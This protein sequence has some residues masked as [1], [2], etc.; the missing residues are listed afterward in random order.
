MQFRWMSASVLAMLLSGCGGTDTQTD[1]VAVQEEKTVMETSPVEG[2][3]F[4]FIETNGIRMRIAEMGD[5]GPLVLLVHGWPESW[6]SWRHQI[7]ALAN[8]GYRVVVPEMRGYGKT[9]APES[10]DDYDIVHLAADMVGVLDA[11][12]VKEGEEKATIVG[13]DWGAIVAVNSVLLHPERFSS[14]VLMSVPYGGRAAASP[15]ESMTARFGDNFFYIL[16]HNEPGG[17]AEAE[18]DADPRGLLSR[19]YLSPGADRE[20]PEVIDPKRSAGGWIPRLGAPKGLP[21]WLDQEELDYYVTQFE[22]SGFRG[23]VNYYRNFQ[24]NWEIT[25]HL[26]DAKIEVPTLFIAGQKDVVIGGA[27]APTLTTMMEGVI[28]DLRGVVIVPEIGHWIQQEDP[29]ATN[30]ALLGFLKS[31]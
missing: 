10:V 27:T 21:G 9:D 30:A 26:A 4:R 16:Y 31:L 24:R 22:S 29:A 14:L 19:L 11:I 13:H 1:S 7:P 28:N 23:G 8:A 17:V 6:F 2:V 20:T 5:E 25:E 12:G 3:T 18:Y 15:L